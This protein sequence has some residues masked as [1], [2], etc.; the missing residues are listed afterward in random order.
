MAT[1]HVYCL[2]DA[3]IE[4]YVAQFFNTHDKLMRRECDLIFENAKKVHDSNP[5]APQGALYR[6]A[7]SY[8]MIHVADFD[9]QTGI[10]SMLDVPITVC[11]FGNVANQHKK[12]DS[13]IYAEQFVSKPKR[14]K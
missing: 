14:V 9:D 1:Q 7:D 8:R 4:T 6:Y 12:S 2:Y 10:Y 3:T 13:Q 11:D 5:L